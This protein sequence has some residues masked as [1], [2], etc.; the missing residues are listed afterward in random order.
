MLK[1]TV[2]NINFISINV[3]GF[4]CT[5]KRLKVIKYFKDRIGLSGFLFLLQE[6]HS[7]VN[8]EITWKNDFK[9][10]AFYSHCKCNLCSGLICFIGSKKLH[11]GNKLSDND[12]RILILDV[13]ID[14]KILS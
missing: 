9:G 13:D 3:K 2:N 1:I 11:I 10:E 8:D 5:N 6:T 4:Q 7:I 12:G 14:D